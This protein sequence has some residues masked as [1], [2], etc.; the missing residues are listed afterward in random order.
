MSKSIERGF[1]LIELIAVTLIVSVLAVTIYPRLSTYNVLLSDSKKQVIDA[2]RHARELSLYRAETNASVAFITSSNTL[3]VRH[4]G[5]SV[6]YP[7]AE[8]PVT[9]PRDLQLSG[10]L[11]VAVFDMLGQTAPSTIA[12]SDGNQTES[13]TISGGGYA[14]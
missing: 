13:I 6:S 5:V 2:V 10:D 1:S 14:Y 9:L 11:G 4:N 7:G 8:Y 12:I 3:D